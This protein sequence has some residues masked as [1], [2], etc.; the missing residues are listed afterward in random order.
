MRAISKRRAAVAA[1]A[2]VCLSAPL[3]LP[4]GASAEPALEMDLSHSQTS[5]PRNAAGVTF[6]ATITNTAPVVANGSVGEELSC[7]RGNWTGNP[8]P[9]FAYRWLKNGVAIPGETGVSYTPTPADEGSAL[10]CLVLGTSLGAGGGSITHAVTTLPVVEV[11]TPPPVGAPRHTNAFVMRPTVTPLNG[12]AQRACNVASMD[13]TPLTGVSYQWLRN[14]VPIPGATAATYLPNVGVGGEDVNVNLQCMVTGSNAGPN[15]TASISANSFTRSANPSALN[16][17]GGVTVIPNSQTGANAPSLIPNQAVNVTVQVDLPSGAVVDAFGS[18]IGWSCVRTA[19]SAVSNAKAICTRSVGLPPQGTPIQTPLI[20]VAFTETVPDPAIAIATASA[21]G[22]AS[23][24]SDQDEITVTPAIPF[25]VTEGSFIARAT[26]LDGVDETQAGAHPARGTAEF[27]MN[28]LLLPDAVGGSTATR[29]VAP[30]HDILTELPPGFVGNPTVAPE[31][32]T[33]GKV[34]LDSWA[35]RTCSDRSI[36][37]WADIQSGGGLA[38]HSNTPIYVVDPGYGAPAQ[39]QFVI[40]TAVSR[41]A[42]TLIPELRHTGDGYAV[43][44]KAPSVPKGGTA[45]ESV[46]VTLCSYGANTEVNSN[47]VEQAAGTMTAAVSCKGKGDPGAFE[48]PLLTNQTSCPDA[49]PVTRLRVDNWFDP[50]AYQTVEYAAPPMTGCDEV[51]FTPTF[52]TELS[53]TSRDVAAGLETRIAVPS[54][55]LEDPDGLSQAHLKKTIVELPEGVSVNPSGATGLAACSDDQLG[56]GS[57][58]APTCPDASKIGTVTATTPLLE[59]TLAG[60]LVLRTPQST[61]P[62]SGDMFRM[63]LIVRNDERGIMVKLPGSATSD[64][65]TGRLIA[66]FDDNPQLPIGNVRVK[67]KGGDRGMLATP[68]VCG[69]VT[70]K[71]TLTPWSGGADVVD[72]RVTGVSSHDCTA[73]FEPKV[74]AG[75]S[76]ANARGFGQYAFKLTRKP[77]EQWVNRLTARLPVGLLASVRGVPLCTSAQAEAGA[78]PAASRIGTVDATAGSGIPFVL[79]QKGSAYLTEGYKGCAYGLL[80]SVPVV[81]GPFDGKTP[82]TDLGSID[83]RQSVCVD[84]VTARVTA[85]SDQFPTIWKGI[86]LRVRSVTVNVDRDRFTLNPSDCSAKLTEARFWSADGAAADATSPFYADGCAALAFKPKLAMRLV[87]RGQVRTGSHPRI[88]AIVTQNGTS[89]AG[90]EKA[91][92][93]LPKSL[94]LDPNNAQALC[95][96]EDGTKADLENHC[97]KGSIVG[98]A[99]AKT[100]LLKNDLVGNVYFV[101]NVRRDPDTG[102]LIRTLPMIVVALRGEIAVNLKGESSTTGAGRLVNTFASVPDA[103]ISQ[104]NLNIDGGENGILAVT[105][106]RRA[107]I[108][109][110]ASRQIAEAQM[111]GHSGR[112]HDFDVRIKTPCT[113]AQIRKAKRS[114]RGR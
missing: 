101:K 112:R 66:T 37:G 67:V 83:V 99:R 35:N 26:D 51:E 11:G 64:P 30:V 27:A 87:G 2:C 25:G 98:R 76:N 102:N 22:T 52:S 48:Q 107:K 60:E 54:D 72:E 23:I 58:E 61:D 62:T 75:M 10:Q 43:T 45:L 32:C 90:I 49:P 13:W 88:K 77:G 56:L 24:A 34:A 14:G 20:A 46:K 19:P 91:V 71:T 111:D 6:R 36:V 18:G 5:I 103:P 41:Q 3:A 17:F 50:G 57:N 73:G 38:S 21:G 4:A 65:T 53:T 94:A 96:F 114:A 16:P 40:L 69:D 29:P 79:E 80:V 8:A 63:A 33:T 93:T 113:R 82:E 89:E 42:I 15:S 1:L 106:T 74:D 39:F 85:A 78:C 59:E 92:V 31:K 28:T 108:N 68:L 47:P 105:R 104:F 70:T 84:P 110:C 12:T 44:V 109:V 100:P 95:E 55:G 86:P 9:T 97:P 81:A 7:G